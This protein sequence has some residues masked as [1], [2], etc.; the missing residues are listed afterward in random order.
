MEDRLVQTFVHEHFGK[1][2]TLI[3]DGKPWFV[4]VDVC[5]ALEIVNTTRA[6]SGLEDDEK[7]IVDL[8]TFQNV[9]GTSVAT[10]DGWIKNEVNVINEPGLYRLVFSSRK[11][12]AKKFQ[13]W[14][15]HEVIPS[16]MHTGMYST[17]GNTDASSDATFTDTLSLEKKIEILLH[18]AILTNLD[19]LRNQILREVLFLLTSKTF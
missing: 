8:N 17:V 7:M 1:I 14:I 5:K 16:I 11:P 2:R 15:Y 18:C 6:L 10:S 12:K 4:A 13:R 9:K 19:R 3:I